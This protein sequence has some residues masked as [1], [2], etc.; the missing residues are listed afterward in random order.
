MT[1]QPEKIGIYE[2]KS[3]L[4]RG[5]MATVYRAYDP[6]F[7]REIAIKFLPSELLHAD[8][9]FRLRFE[10]EAKIIAQLEHTAIV[11]VYDVGESDGQPYFV[12]RYMNG[13]SRSDRIKAGIITIDETARILGIS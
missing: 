6:R 12:M 3:E 5:G 8:P 10:R 13:G 7:E 4:C 9:K 2:V 1:M 11:P